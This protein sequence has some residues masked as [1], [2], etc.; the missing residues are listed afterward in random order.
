VPA[1]AY[2]LARCHDRLEHWDLAV[3]LYREYLET[4]PSDAAEVTQ[5]VTLLERRLAGRRAA[6]G[7]SLRVAGLTV[8]AV[9]LACAGV[10]VAFGVL[11]NGAAVSLNQLDLTHGAYDPGLDARYVVDRA[12]EGTFLAV[13]AAAVIVGTTLYLTGRLGRRSRTDIARA[14]SRFE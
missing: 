12:L 3:R 1:L 11:G 6:R 5:R 14:P 10:G 9:G 13:G 2:N 8:G 7:A 4:H